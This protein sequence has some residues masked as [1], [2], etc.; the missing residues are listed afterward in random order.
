QAHYNTGDNVVLRLVHTEQ[1]SYSSS[2]DI[3]TDLNRLQTPGD[4]FLDNVAGLRN[5]FGADL[6]SLISTPSFQGGLSN[7]LTDV[8]SPIRQTLAFS[9][10]NASAIGPGSFVMAHELGH[11]MGAGHERDNLIDP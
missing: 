2:G 11:Y 8:N 6:V 1:V 3:Q 5:T 10:I 9:V 7:L 4:G